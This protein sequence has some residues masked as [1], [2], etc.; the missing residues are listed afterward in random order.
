MEYHPMKSSSSASLVLRNLGVT[1]AALAMQ[2]TPAVA[3]VVISDGFDDGDRTSAVD[4]I[5]WYTHSHPLDALGISI[6]DDSAGLGSGNA[7]R[8]EPITTGQSIMGVFGTPIFVPAAIGS[9]LTLRFEMRNDF[10]GGAVPGTFRF[11]LYDAKTNTAGDEE[12]FPNAAGFGGTDG[13]WDAAQPGSRFDPG[14]HV[15]Q[16]NDVAQTCCPPTATRLREE[17]GAFGTQFGGG[18]E[19]NVAQPAGAFPGLN[20]ADGKNI[21]TLEVERLAAGIEAGALRYTYTLN[22][23]TETDSISG[24]KLGSEFINPLTTDTYD[25]FS[26]FYDGVSEGMARW[27]IDN[28]T[29]DVTTPGQ[30]LVGDY[31]EDGTVNAADYTVWRDGGSPDDTI[32]GYNLWKANFGNSGGG[33]GSAVPEP[34]SCILVLTAIVAWAGLRRR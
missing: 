18:D 17:S 22:N 1:L 12:A 26:L 25:Y 5:D 33:A 24:L 3:E 10:F 11:G 27:L 28:V 16:D 21:L 29:I 34:S 2:A 14:I 32:A 30:D 13:D 9:K 6:V 7:L 8:V 20:Q 31:N 15:Q 19:R 4:G 23:G